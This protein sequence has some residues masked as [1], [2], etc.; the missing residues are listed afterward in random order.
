MLI[1]ALFLSFLPSRQDNHCQP[2]PLPYASQAPRKPG[3]T[4]KECLKMGNVAVSA[5]LFDEWKL[6]LIE[7]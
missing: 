3:Q 6:M 4:R 5:T 2:Q 7:P 1:M